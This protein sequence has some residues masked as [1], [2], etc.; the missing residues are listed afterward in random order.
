MSL[1]SRRFDSPQPYVIA[2]AFVMLS[3]GLATA[4]PVQAPNIT[5]VSEDPPCFCWADGHKIAEGLTACIR[6][7]TG[8]RLAE[9]SRVTNLMSWRVSEEICPE[10]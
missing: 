7:S 9:C 1:L 3:M 8:R 6:T 10:S 4:Q 5:P 2:A